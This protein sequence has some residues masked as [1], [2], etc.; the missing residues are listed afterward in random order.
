VEFGGEVGMDEKG[1]EGE[2]FG[3]GVDGEATSF[4]EIEFRMLKKREGVLVKEVKNGR[5]GFFGDGMG[6]NATQDQAI[7][8]WQILRYVELNPCIGER[9]GPI[10]VIH[11]S[12]IH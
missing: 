4:K 9:L 2:V 10:V 3:E 6:I 12:P 7:N 11:H 5:G 8:P 1:I